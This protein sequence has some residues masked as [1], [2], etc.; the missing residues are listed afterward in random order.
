[1]TDEVG[2]VDQYGRV[3]L[4]PKIV[5]DPLT[6]PRFGRWRGGLIHPDR[7]RFVIGRARHDRECRDLNGWVASTNHDNTTTW[8]GLCS[9][10]H[11]RDE[12]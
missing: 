10:C 9:I 1:M 8:W 5:P 7:V 11:P 3:L 4:D 6:A 2:S 12:G